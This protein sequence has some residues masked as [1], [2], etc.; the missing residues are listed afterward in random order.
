MA[1]EQMDGARH[2][3]DRADVYAVGVILFLLLTARL[4]FEGATPRATLLS[5]VLRDAPDVR[6]LQPEASETLALLVSRCLEKD[7]ELRPSAEALARELGTF[8]E[9]NGV[10][11]LDVLERDGA[12]QAEKS[13]TVLSDTLVEVRRKTPA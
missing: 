4:P 1:P 10:A 2:V 3:T 7:P 11:P 13:S 8:A 9:D 6:S 5:A 12:L